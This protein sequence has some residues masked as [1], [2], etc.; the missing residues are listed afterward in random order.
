MSRAG[1]T[2]S[3]RAPEPTTGA[4]EG[5]R[6]GQGL[7]FQDPRL[8]EQQPGEIGER[9]GGAVLAGEIDERAISGCLGLISRMRFASPAPSWLCWRSSRSRWM[10]RSPSS[11]TRQTALSVSR[12][13][14]RTSFTASPSDSLNSAIS[15]RYRLGLPSAGFAVLLLLG[16]DL[17]EI[18]A[19]ARHRFERMVLVLAD[20]GHPELVDRIGQQQH[21]DAAGAE[22]FELRASLERRRD[23]R[24]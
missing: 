6:V 22:A 12:F 15:A 3:G 23:C 2:P 7:A 16:R 17:V 1:F 9:V 18:G 14:A 8:V 24:R 19:A 4:G 10:S 21:L 5:R 11:A 13:E 20:R